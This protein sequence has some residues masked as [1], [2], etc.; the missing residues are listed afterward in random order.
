MKNSIKYFFVLFLLLLL[1]GC[2]TLNGISSDFSSLFGKATKT[3]QQ[4]VI[5]QDK[6]ADL[7]NQQIEEASNGAYEADLIL[8]QDPS[9]DKNPYETG[10][11][12]VLETD[13]VPN[14][15]APITAGIQ[16]AQ[17]RVD[18]EVKEAQQPSPELV[19][20]IKALYD[21]DAA[22]N[23]KISDMQVQEKANL[24][25]LKQ[26][27]EQEKAELVAKMQGQINQETAEK[28][29]ANAQVV[30]EEQKQIN[31]IFAGLGGICVLAG[32]LLIAFTPLKTDG[33]CLIALG[34]CIAPMGL[35]YSSPWFKWVSGIGFGILFIAFIVIIFRAFVTKKQSGYNEDISDVFID[36]TLQLKTNNEACYD[37]FKTVL[38][39]KLTGADVDPT[40]KTEIDKRINDLIS[41]KSGATSTVTATIPIIQST[42][43][44]VTTPIVTNTT[45]NTTVN[46]LTK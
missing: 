33:G 11:V 22:N 12:Q 15:P 4:I 38:D 7:G 25:K 3:Q 44:P 13:V 35:I 20:Q 42:I 46:P 34:L 39:D 23:K 26:Q 45:S 5:S 43:T 2:N 16:E 1:V 17:T 41:L 29:A 37:V 31:T 18:L 30:A 8:K 14:L 19:A 10:A 40:L 36:A 9:L 6:I 28:N 24:E 21:K 32:I 27:S